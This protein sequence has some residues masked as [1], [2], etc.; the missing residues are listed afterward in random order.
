MEYYGNERQGG[1]NGHFYHVFNT[2]SLHATGGV[3]LRLITPLQPLYYNL[4]EDAVL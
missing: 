3:N 2:V 4:P 1:V